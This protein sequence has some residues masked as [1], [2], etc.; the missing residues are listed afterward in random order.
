MRVIILTFVIAD[1]VEA[2]TK[3]LTVI[4]SDKFFEADVNKLNDD[5]REGQQIIALMTYN[6]SAH[7]PDVVAKWKE[8]RNDPTVPWKDKVSLLKQEYPGGI[9]NYVK[10]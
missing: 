9:E 7:I 10:V 8:L 5:L 2:R 3:R 4:S 1:A 6:V